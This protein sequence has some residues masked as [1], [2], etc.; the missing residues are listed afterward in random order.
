MKKKIICILL[1]V[2]SFYSSGQIM[3]QRTY[4]IGTYNE[5]RS[6][7]QTLDG[8]YIIAGTVSDAGLG[9]PDV[10]LLKVDQ[11]GNP[12]WNKLFGGSNIDRGYA[13]EQLS[14]SGYA[15]AG[16]TNSYGNGGYDGYLVRTDKNGDSLWTKTYGTTNWDFIY[17]LKKT[18]DNGFILAGNSYG[19]L[20]G[21]SEAWVLKADSSGIV[22]WSKQL[23][24]PLESFLNT[25]IETPEN[26][27]VAVGYNTGG[28]NGSEDILVL[29]VNAAGDSIW[30]HSFGNAGNDVGTAV[31]LT[32][33]GNYIVGGT[34]ENISTTFGD[35]YFLKINTSGNEIWH[36]EFVSS[37]GDFLYSIHQLNNGGYVT[38]GLSYG[39]GG[40]G[41]DVSLILTYPNGDPSSSATYG[42]PLYDLAYDLNKCSDNGFIIVGKTNGTGP[43]TGNIYLIK[44]DS[45]GA[46][47]T[48]IT[49][50]VNEI[51]KINDGFFFYP[52][53][54]GK[55]LHLFFKEPGNVSNEPV[56][57][58]IY[59]L[60][61]QK[62]FSK[63]EIP[64][65]LNKDIILNVESIEN[66]C[67]VLSVESN[68]NSIKRKL[69][70]SH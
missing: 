37:E 14:D 66:G 70:I 21:A 11:F 33:D 53:P 48:T 9:G 52:N 2:G 43:A 1:C 63:R 27:F 58:N 3:F 13:V 69:L 4:G 36:Q 29:K 35:Y 18:S 17:S 61:G 59:N 31:D 20:S 46:T 26:D 5:G 55:F 45:L 8:G 24:I 34:I 32:N 60:S 65:S 7:K 57:I 28:I 10:Y 41:G 19:N 47:S 54:A 12:Q 56:E 15:V 42:T 49:I 40:G 64:G 39:A 6:V 16:Y 62:V 44:T 67:Y 25:I 23:A 51:I 50:F 68:V 30:T 22:E 38:C